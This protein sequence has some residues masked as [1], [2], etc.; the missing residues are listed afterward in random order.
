MKSEKKYFGE[1]NRITCVIEGPKILNNLNTK[2]I[3]Y[4]I[5]YL[6]S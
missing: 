1:Q 4:P 6:H 3:F 2:N 5:F